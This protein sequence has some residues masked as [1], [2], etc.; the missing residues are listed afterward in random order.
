MQC[1]HSMHTEVEEQPYSPSLRG[2]LSPPRSRSR[3]TCSSAA[4]SA[5]RSLAGA[6]T[7]RGTSH[8][9]ARPCPHSLPPPP[10]P[11]VH[12]PSTRCSEKLPGHWK[13]RKCRRTCVRTSGRWRRRPAPRSSVGCAQT[14][15]PWRR[16]SLTAC[17]LPPLLPL[18][19]APLARPLC[20]PLSHRPACQLPLP[21]LL[22]LLLL[23][24]LM[25]LFV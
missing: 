6:T 10:P 1:T 9:G 5:S 18:P 23:L 20:P 16:A 2:P 22:Q 15:A 13:A 24:L 25:L 3:S 14:T 8:S 12:H 21:H 19:L 7:A 17:P 4:A 11:P